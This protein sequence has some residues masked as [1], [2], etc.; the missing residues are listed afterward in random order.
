MTSRVPL[1]LLPLLLGCGNQGYDITA[2]KRELGTNLATFDAGTV[3]VG[4]T[5][6]VIIYVQST[7]RGDVTLSGAEVD[8]PDHWEI[9]PSSWQVDDADGDGTDESQTIPGGSKTDPMYGHLEILFHADVEGDFRTV[10]TLTSDDT[11]VTER[12]EDDHGVWR[13]VLRVIARYPCVTMYPEVLDYGPRASDGF[14]SEYAYLQNCGVVTA[15][16]DGFSLKGDGSFY[17]DTPTPFYVLPA[18]TEEVQLAWLPVSSDPV[19][20]IVRPSTNDPVF[21]E[22]VQLRGNNCEDSLEEG[23]D[24]DG[25]GWLSCA[26]DCDDKNA[27]INPSALEVTD[28]N[29]DDDCD[30]SI[31]ESPNGLDTDEDADGFTEN[32]GDCQD[33]DP[34]I[35][36]GAEELDNQV[37]DDCDGFIDNGSELADDDGDGFS[38]VEGDCIDELPQVHPGATELLNGY[39]DDCDQYIDETTTAYDDDDDGFAEDDAEP[40]CNDDDPWTYPGAI[41]DCDQRDNDCDGVVDEGEDGTEDGACA[42]IVERQPSTVADGGCGKSA[43]G[44]LFLGGLGALGRRRRRR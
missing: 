40:D 16:I 15:T 28:N 32:Q 34:T 18:G 23:W 4:D 13:V 21:K 41:E 44:L 8:D 1:L 7:A 3:A 38:E 22:T 2:F 17:V 30:G 6:S 42:F 31:D 26:G 29:K 36:P 10:L 25:D 19:D 33:L 14:Y 20:A 5:E 27:K 35:Y 24:A 9:V 11:E 12:T 43:A 37:D 39:D